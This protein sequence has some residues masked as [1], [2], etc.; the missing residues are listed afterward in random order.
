MRGPYHCPCCGEQE[1]TGGCVLGLPC[2]C[3]DTPMCDVCKHCINHHVE[4]CTE[5]VRV[6]ALVLIAKLRKRH[7]INIF[8]VGKS[9]SAQFGGPRKVAS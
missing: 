4:Q 6:E 3:N 7:G 2:R 9:D 5:K 8:H 1:R